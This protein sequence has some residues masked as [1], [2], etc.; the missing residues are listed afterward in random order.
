MRIILAFV[1]ISS[2][3]TAVF[4]QDYSFYLDFQDK[5]ISNTYFLEDGGT[6]TTDNSLACMRPDHVNYNASLDG[7]DGQRG[8]VVKMDNFDAVCSSK[9]EISTGHLTSIMEY[10]YGN[11]DIFAKIAHSPDGTSNFIR[12]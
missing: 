12:V 8:L 9:A 5:A 1:E 4:C 11:F 10:L 7:S 6:L 3:L 2:I